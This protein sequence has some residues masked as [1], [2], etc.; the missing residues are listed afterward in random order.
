[1]HQ[2]L[3]VFLRATHAHQW[4]KNLLLGVPLLL[5]HQWSNPQALSRVAIAFAALSL[6][7]SA[8]YLLNDFMDVTH[9]R[10]HP[11]KR[12]R[13]LASGE[14]TTGVAIAL[15][16][17]LVVGAAALSLLIPSPFRWWM[18]VY[19]ITTVLYSVRLKRVV[20]LDVIVL[21]GL[22]V[23]RLAAGATAAGVQVSRWLLA[24]AVFFFFGLA[25]VKRTAELMRL[26]N[27]G[28]NEARGRGYLQ[29]D[30]EVIMA[31]GT[32]ASMAATVVLALYIDSQEVVRLYR[33]PALL[34]AV[35]VVLFYWQSRVWMLAHRGQ[36]TEDPV[37]FAIRDFVSLLCA[38]CIVTTIVAAAA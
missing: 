10:A 18:L 4:S 35:C 1:M 9:D 38:A 30:V 24:F 19:V 6:M 31:L 27:E 26:R 33:T 20:M 8:G 34:W 13:P 36:M 32:A 3:L 22:Y 16:V 21:A 15:G 5:A 12:H 37:V 17:V 23:L 11:D 28:G 2:S 25:L 14:I 7:A 29:R